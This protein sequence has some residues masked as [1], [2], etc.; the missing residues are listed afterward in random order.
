MKYVAMRLVLG[1][2]LVASL[3]SMPGKALGACN[4]DEC[5][6]EAL[7]TQVAAEWA[8]IQTYGYTPQTTACI[9]AVRATWME[10]RSWC[11]ENCELG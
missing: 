8:C 5:Y 1:L 10:Q 3:L 7:N 11:D 9:D 2:A 6:Q 4:R